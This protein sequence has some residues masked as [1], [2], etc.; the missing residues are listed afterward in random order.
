MANKDAPQTK[1]SLPPPELPE[2]HNGVVSLKDVPEAGMSFIVPE[3][4]DISA[5]DTVVARFGVAGD[6]FPWEVKHVVDRPVSFKLFVPRSVLLDLTGKTAYAVYW[7]DTP[8]YPT[9]PDVEVKIT[10]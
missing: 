4:Y 3:H 8:A 5:G 1:P 6:D 2:A 7:V 9:S 10:H